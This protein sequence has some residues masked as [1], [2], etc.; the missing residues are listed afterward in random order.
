MQIH[1]LKLTFQD[2]TTA[3]G[4]K[5]A[6][7]LGTVFIDTGKKIANTETLKPEPEFETINFT[8]SIGANPKL[9]SVIQ[10]WV[11]PSTRF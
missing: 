2:I 1:S 5:L 9:K 6:V 10:E 3:D 4:A 11:K 8:T 7:V